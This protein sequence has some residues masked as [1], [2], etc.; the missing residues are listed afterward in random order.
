MTGAELMEILT[1]WRFPLT[2]EK[3]CQEEIARVLE[4]ASVPFAREHRL[5][6]GSIIDFLVE[7]VG[8]E[9]KLG[10]SKRQ[11]WRQCQRYCR[12]DA[13]SELVVATNVPIGLPSEINGKPTYL[14]PLSRAWM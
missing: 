13:I 12:F 4:G 10:G 1:D 11:L 3:L 9:V 8:I 14:L 2:S 7:K 5:A 6:K